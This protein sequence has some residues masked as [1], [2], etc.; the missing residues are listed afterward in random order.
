MHKVFL[1]NQDILEKKTPYIIAEA[2][3]NHEG[4]IEKAFDLIS[5]ASDSGAHAIKFQ[6]YKA[7]SLASIH[8]PAYW[9]TDMELSK[10]QHELFKK[11]DSFNGEDYKKLYDHCIKKNIDFL[12]TPFDIKSL[13]FLDPLLNFYKIASADINN[14]PL[15]K[16]IANKNKP[17]ILSTGASNIEEIQFAVDYLFKNGCPDISLLHCILNYPT[18]YKNANLNMIKNLKNTFPNNTIGYSDH[19][20]PDKDMFTLICA[21]LLGAKIIEKHFTLDKTLPGNDH[22]HSMDSNDLKIFIN[23]LNKLHEI[24]GDYLKKSLESEKNARLNARRSIVL[25]CNLSKGEVITESMIISKR[26]GTGIAPT[27]FD[28]VIGQ[29]INK[30]LE[31]DHI[32]KWDDLNI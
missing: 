20:L 8:S 29:S 1:K 11:Y 7:D 6:T 25:N 17:I 26:P 2:G 31:K 22:Y 9:D 28:K 19:T 12:S 24:S 18:E 15:L 13:D 16:A 4:S 23:N 21:Y 27:E 3:V 10:N 14:L 32:L 5:C 30:N